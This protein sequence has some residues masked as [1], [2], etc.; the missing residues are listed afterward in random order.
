MTNKDNAK[1]LGM[2]GLMIVTIIG[3]GIQRQIDGPTPHVVNA[4]VVE[5]EKP[6]PTPSEYIGELIY[7]IHDVIPTPTPEFENPI[8][9]YIY[10]TFGDHYDKAMLVLRGNGICGGENR[11]LNPYAV[12][13]NKTDDGIVWSRDRG[14]FQVNSVFHPLTDEQAFDYKQNIEYSWR[15]FENDGNTFSKRWSAGKCLVDNGYEV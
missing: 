6:T 7:E 10:N 8:E 9:Q 3:N 11:G 2:I 13:E 14:I 1:V 15:M 4:K 5:E 12:Y